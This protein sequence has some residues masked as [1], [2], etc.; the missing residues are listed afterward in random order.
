MAT[1]TSQATA[2]LNEHSTSKNGTY[3]YK[4][5]VITSSSKDDKGE[6]QDNYLYVTMFSKENLLTDAT[7]YQKKP[8]LIEFN[9]LNFTT[10]WYN[11]KF[12]V[13]HTA[14]ITALALKPIKEKAVDQNTG[15][16]K[17]QAQ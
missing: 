12:Y 8:L 6:W 10:N 11:D 2:F 4:L 9:G 15:F 13:N 7:S 14:F 16:S 17:P 3:I 5:S 1:M